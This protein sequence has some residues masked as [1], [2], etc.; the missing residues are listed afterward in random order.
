MYAF[1][2]AR[3]DPLYTHYV[4]WSPDVP[5]FRTDDGA[6]LEEPWPCSFLTCAAVMAKTLL[7]DYPERARKLPP[8]MWERT[9]KVLGIA[10]EKGQDTLV[11]GAWGCGAFGYDPSVMAAQFHRA[12]TEDFAGAF[13]RVEFAIVDDSPE[14]RTI[15]PF[16]EAF[17][18]EK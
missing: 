11:L 5:V 14:E 16:R 10:A 12:L 3:R 17:V 13:A 1:H 18:G 7:R 6:L 2:R 8:T 9:L 4:L 15:G